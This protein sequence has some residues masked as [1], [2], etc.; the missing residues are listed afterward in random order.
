MER[1]V[2]LLVAV[3]LLVIGVSHLV[4][5]RVWVDY[6]RDLSARGPVGAFVDGFIC[7]SFGAIVVGFH[8]VWSGPAVGITLIG[9]GQ[10]LKGLIRF[11]FPEQSARLLGRISADRAWLFQSGGVMALALSGYAW[12][13]YLSH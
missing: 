10:V 13:L 7:L 1:G 5:P 11:V 12:W 2:Q 9:W 6:F 8:N 3:S 4:R